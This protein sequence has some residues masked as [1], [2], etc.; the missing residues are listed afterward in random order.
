MRTLGASFSL[1]GR[2][3][4]EEDDDWKPRPLTKYYWAS[5]FTLSLICRAMVISSS[6]IDTRSSTALSPSPN[7]S[8]RRIMAIRRA[9]CSQVI[10]TPSQLSPRYPRYPR[11]F[12][13]SNLRALSRKP[14][15]R[16]RQRASFRP[17]AALEVNEQLVFAQ[18]YYRV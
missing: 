13:L 9:N 1:V 17:P 10:C 7:S 12:S 11:T 15:G 8:L 5:V 4:F 14:S 3:S 18:K 2:F 16:L 6:S